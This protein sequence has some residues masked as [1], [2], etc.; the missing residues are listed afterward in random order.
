MSP[1]LSL[2]NAI[3]RILRSVAAAAVWLLPLL[4]AVIV[5]DVITRKFGLFLPILTSSRLQELEWHVHA[6]L[7]ALWL[8]FAYSINGHPRVDPLHAR[9]SLRGKARVE[10]FGCLVFAL[11]YALVL[12]YYLGP[13]LANS[14]QS[15]EGS[16]IPGGL[17]QR[18]IV[19]SVFAAGFVLLALSIVS[20]ILRTCAYLFARETPEAA[21]LPFAAN[22]GPTL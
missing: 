11:P 9:M 12:L 16:N 6:S 20:M 8:G 15:G 2:A 4:A 17:P 13:F 14:Y 22:D 19:K 21:R 10:L 1:L 5:V 18:W 3:D 7:F